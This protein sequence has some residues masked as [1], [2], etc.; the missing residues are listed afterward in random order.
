MTSH[1]LATQEFPLQSSWLHTFNQADLERGQHSH[2]ECRLCRFTQAPST[3]NPKQRKN[4]L[5]TAQYNYFTEPTSILSSSPRKKIST[6]QSQDYRFP[7]SARKRHK[8]DTYSDTNMKKNVVRH[9][10]ARCEN[11]HPRSG[12]LFALHCYQRVYVVWCICVHLHA[13]VNST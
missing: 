7:F 9:A 1:C 8:N 4:A 3:G 12:R 10:H 6:E 11:W 5:T 13:C 2:N